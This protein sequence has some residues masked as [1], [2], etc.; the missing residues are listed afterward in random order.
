VSWAFG[1]NSKGR[2]I[3]YGLSATCDV[4]DCETGIDRGLAY[5]C[6]NLDGVEGTHGCGHYYCGEH[7]V[8]HHCESFCGEAFCMGEPWHGMEAEDFERVPEVS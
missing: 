1:T 8:H 6:G 4:I 5:C 2:D 3:G 7:E